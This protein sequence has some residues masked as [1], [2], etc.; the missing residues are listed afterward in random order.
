[1]HSIQANWRT[2]YGVV[3]VAV[4]A[5]FTT[6]ALLPDRLGR[7][8]A[9]LLIVVILSVLMLVWVRANRPGLTLGAEAERGLILQSNRRIGSVHTHQFIAPPTA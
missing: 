4:A 2:L 9:D 8:V 5:L 6:D 3:A 1:M 7:T